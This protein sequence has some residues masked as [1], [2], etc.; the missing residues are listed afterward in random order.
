MED[1]KQVY[2]LM[3]FKKKRL[4][5]QFKGDNVKAFIKTSNCKNFV[6][7]QHLLCLFGFHWPNNRLKMV[8]V[9]PNDQ[10]YMYPRYP[11]VLK[12]NFTSARPMRLVILYLCMETLVRWSVL[13]SSWQQMK[14]EIWCGW[15]H[16]YTTIAKLIV[17]SIFLD[18]TSAGYRLVNTDK[19][20]SNHPHW[21]RQVGAQSL[22][23]SEVHTT[24]AYNNL[25][26]IDT[27]TT[28]PVVEQ[29]DMR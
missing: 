10:K 2:F 16:P 20:L 6:K 11:L 19:N 23:T 18:A 12:F 25:V 22:L 13:V 9:S 24:I 4:E 17:H 15:A 1:I 29:C 14:L 27:M 8:L 3:R 28:F 26:V 21:Q 5:T 7:L